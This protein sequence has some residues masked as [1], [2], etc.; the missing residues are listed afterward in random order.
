MQNIILVGFMGT[1]KSSVGQYLARRLGCRFVDM[2]TLIESRV[3]KPIT[4][5]FAEDG[6][7]S[8][9]NTERTLVQELAR[10]SNQVIAAGGGT[11]LNPN[12]IHD[13]SQS[14]QVICLSA[15]PEE[16]LARISN[17]YQRP[18]LNQPNPAAAIRKLLTQRQP[19]YS[20]IPF[21]VDTTGKTVQEVA[22]L[23]MALLS[24]STKS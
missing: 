22:E 18:L 24:P 20:A 1:G 16:I 5:I 7:A 6:E 14:G 11:V 12:N 9:R 2:D 10:Q 21:Q 4:R 13:F 19:Y 3:G 17:S 23:I 15:S 8:F